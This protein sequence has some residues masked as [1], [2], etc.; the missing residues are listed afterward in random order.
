MTK[1]EAMSLLVGG[2]YRDWNNY[3]KKNPGWKPDLSGVDLSRIK[4]VIHGF[5]GGQFD[6]TGANL[7]GANLSVLEN[8]Q[9]KFQDSIKV[10]D[11]TQWFENIKFLDLSGAQIDIFTKFPS[12]F[13]A[14]THGAILLSM[15]STDT[16]KPRQV[17]ISYARANEAVVLSV[18]QWL[19]LKGL[20]TKMDRRDFFAGSEIRAE[21]VRVMQECDVV[22]VFYSSESKDK[23]WIQFE[24][25]LASNLEA[26]AK[27]TGKKPP[28][29]IYFVIDATP[30]PE[31]VEEKR[32]AVV[33]KGKQFEVACEELY[34]GILQI[35]RNAEQIDLNKWSNFTF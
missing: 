3:R 22:V 34:Y 25:E 19:R 6:L 35:A 17:F 2:R 18:D 26:E 21:I 12:S 9:A 16:S 23:P 33:A 20:K 32:I 28:T 31:G 14:T 8:L 30:L 29:V 15:Q 7:C 5:S 24:R 27:K 1:E 13:Q 10:G 11:K 4:L